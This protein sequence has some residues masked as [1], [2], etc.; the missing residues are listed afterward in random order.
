M[1]RLTVIWISFLIISLMFAG[2]SYA[3]IDTKT[4]IGVWLFDE[5]GG[6][7]AQDSSINGNDGTLNGPEWT[8]VSKFGGALEFNGT[9]AYIEF[10][11]G[12]L[13]DMVIYSRRVMIGTIWPDMYLEF[14][15]MDMH[16]RL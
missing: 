12:E 13:T 7:V 16:K 10:A 5:G 2:Q 15:K 3:K 11:T 14:T 8:N 9:D 1:K 6:E 4:V